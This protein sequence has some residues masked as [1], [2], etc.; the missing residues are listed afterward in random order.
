MQPEPS[1]LGDVQDKHLGVLGG[2]MRVAAVHEAREQCHHWGGGFT[3]KD[4]HPLV[5]A[6]KGFAFTAPHRPP[7]S[8]LPQQLTR[9][10]NVG[11]PEGVVANPHH[12]RISDLH[13]AL[14]L[15]RL[16]PQ[17]LPPQ[18]HAHDPTARLVRGWR[19]LPNL[20]GVRRKPPKLRRL[21]YQVHAHRAPTDLCHAHIDESPKLLRTQ[22][23]GC[24]VAHGVLPQ[25]VEGPRSPGVQDQGHVEVRGEAVCNDGPNHMLQCGVEH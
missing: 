8:L 24:R 20:G 23:C 13:R 1:R 9:P 3:A 5:D 12:E 16:I 2:K 7:G 19:V 21:R 11:K 15:E 17:L 22:R 6:S 10:P 18:E 25:P 4:H 14:A